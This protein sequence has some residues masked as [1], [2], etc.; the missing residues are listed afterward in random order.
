MLSRD[1][2]GVGSD[3]AIPLKSLFGL[4]MFTCPNLSEWATRVPGNK[5]LGARLPV[6]GEMKMNIKLNAACLGGFLA[7]TSSWRSRYWQM[8]GTRERN[9]SSARRWRFRKGARAGKYVF[10]IIGGETNRNIVQVSQRIRTER[11]PCRY[12]DGEPGLY[13]A[14]AR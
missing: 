2:L 7:L 4:W 3:K 1:Q 12:A 5:K 14:D 9:S 11:K 6:K 13:G 8:S 10:R